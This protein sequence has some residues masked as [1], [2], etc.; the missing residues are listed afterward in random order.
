MRRKDREVTD[1][2]EIRNILNACKTASIA[3]I[4]GEMP[5]VVPLSYG[6][7]LKGDSLV[8]YFHCAKEGRK[9][10]VLK[11]N[12]KV[13]FVIFQEGE[14]LYAEKAPCSSGYYYSSVIGDG[15][16]SLIEDSAGKRYALQKMFAQQA[17]KTIEFTEAQADTVCVFQIVSETY[18]GKRKEKR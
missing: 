9:L 2:D 3:M 4:D 10:E 18:T 17:G 7:E 11:R 6:Y 8:L 12:P 15:V 13:C 16:A 5:Y 1:I 14:P